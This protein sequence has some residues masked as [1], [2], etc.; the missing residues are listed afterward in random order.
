MKLMLKKK[1]ETR[2]GFYSP[3]RLKI[4][5]K[6]NTKNLKISDKLSKNIVCLPV[7]NDLSDK[8]VK[9]IAYNF[10]ELID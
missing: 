5:K 9:Y 6:F 10:L 3:N 7:Y 2:N 1:I 8:Q 4:Y